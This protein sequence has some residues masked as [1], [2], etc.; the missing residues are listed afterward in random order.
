MISEKTL[1]ARLERQLNERYG[2][3]LEAEHLA[4]VLH[5]QTGGLRW[6]LTQDTDFARKVNST[7]V[8]IGRRNY[9][10]AADLAVLL[11]GEGAVDE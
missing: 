9:Y 5:R 2:L 7:R 1:A 6:A 11:A 4:E 3:L 8:R 10:R